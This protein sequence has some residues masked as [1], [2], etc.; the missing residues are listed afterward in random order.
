MLSLVFIFA[1]LLCVA[2]FS[3]S[4][5]GKCCDS[6]EGKLVDCGLYSDR[7]CV[8]NLWSRMDYD[9]YKKIECCE[10]KFAG[11]AGLDRTRTCH[12]YHDMKFHWRHG[13]KRYTGGT[14]QHEGERCPEL[15]C[16][17]STETRT[18]SGSVIFWVCF[19]IGIIIFFA[20]LLLLGLYLKGY[21]PRCSKNCCCK[22][23]CCKPTCCTRTGNGEV[24]VRVA[25]PYTST[26]ISL[27]P[28][29]CASA[30]FEVGDKILAWYDKDGDGIWCG[31]TVATINVPGV[32]YNIVYD[33]GD[34]DLN[35]A[36]SRMIDA[37]QPDADKHFKVLDRILVRCDDGEVWDQATV[38]MVN[39]PGV[40]YKIVYDDGDT[41]A[42]VP[43]SRMITANNLI[44]IESN[45]ITSAPINLGSDGS[46][47]AAAASPPSLPPPSRGGVVMAIAVAAPSPIADFC[48]KCGT[49]RQ[50]GGTFCHRC[51][52][53][54][55]NMVE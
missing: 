40:S 22:P 36:V 28:I 25:Q 3:Q 32:S 41:E 48:P 14:C 37:S 8:R 20:S 21:F 5:V 33:D 31:A 53:D 43:P 35:I 45:P 24:N 6:G 30:Y 19:T 17:G 47:S 52:E 13:E 9:C 51:G 27:P 18:T 2:S 26:G 54:L 23:T 7:V 11:C 46:A 42:N 1:N 39:E 12:N 50:E 16:E 38:T 29:P 4:D 49:R 34:E 15:V 44:D 55:T 10:T